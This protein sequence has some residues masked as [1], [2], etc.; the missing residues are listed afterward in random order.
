MAQEQLWQGGAWE[1]PQQAVSPLV[2]PEVK[3][4]KR[5]P[6]RKRRIIFAL[7]VLLIAA[8]TTA[9]VILSQME[10]YDLLPGRPGAGQEQRDEHAAPWEQNI[11]IPVAGV[12]GAARL[13]LYGKGEQAF[14][15]QEI[16]ERSGA[17]I[18]YI[19]AR[20][21]SGEVNAGSGVIMTSDGYILTNAHV[22]AGASSVQVVFQDNRALEAGLVG[23]QTDYDLAVLKVET[24]DLTPAR[25]GSSADL[26]VGD[27][28]V[29]IGN[30]LGSTLR[31]TMTQ[32][33]VSAINRSV[34]LDGTTMPLI[35][36]TAALNP[37]NS[38]GA[39]INDRGQVVGI[40]TMKMMSRYETIE[41]LGFAIPTRLVKAVVDQIIAD[42][43][44]PTPALGI[45]VVFDLE[46]YGG[47]RV[48]EVKKDSDAWAKGLRSGDVIVAV[49][50]IAMTDDSI[51]LSAKETLR[52]GD[53]LTVRVDREGECLDLVIVLMDSKLF[54]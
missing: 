36:T 33:I 2:L 14:T 54:E 40:T 37:G 35:Q 12:G 52:V 20:H 24:R 17:S 43:T 31:G 15:P 4:K 49:N 29:A 34:D 6:T 32:G 27:M 48:M 50:G 10:F 9:G 45:T 46:R 13:E 8:L 28:V 22:L 18:V 1:Q 39:L 42:G 25:F 44:A 41:G 26:R 16:Y 11:T 21:D 47:L 19:Q 38:G 23:Y 53:S 51:L 30:P 5:H 3:Q 7:F